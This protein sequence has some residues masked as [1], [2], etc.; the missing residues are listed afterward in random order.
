MNLNIKKQYKT[1]VLIVSAFVFTLFTSQK[2]NDKS[3]SPS[4]PNTVVEVDSAVE[5]VFKFDYNDTYANQWKTVDSL[6]SLGLY[7]SSLNVVVQIFDKAKK[8]ENH[9][10]VIKALM[11]KQKYNSYITDEDFVAAIAELDSIALVAKFPL[12][13]IA[14]AITADVY[15]GYFQ[16][17]QW[18]VGQRTFSDEIVKSDIR[19]WDLRTLAH[20]IVYH[21]IQSTTEATKLQALPL[22]AYKDILRY[23]GYALDHQKRED[24]DKF[25]PTLYDF[26]AFEAIKF[27]QTASYNVSQ[28][29]DKYVLDN[30]AILGNNADFINM[31]HQS[32]DSLSNHYYAVELFKTLTL[33]HIKDADPSVLV[34]ITIKRIEFAKNYAVLEN[35]EE[36]YVSLINEMEKLYASHESSTQFSYLKAQNLHSK[37][38]PLNKDNS[39]IQ[40]GNKLAYEICAN[41]QKLYPN[42]YG[43]KQ[44]K[45]LMNKLE[46][47]S[48][49]VTLDKYLV[50]ATTQKIKLS[51]ANIDKVYFTL[52]LVP[53]DYK[54]PEYEHQPKVDHF[55][56][57]GKKIKSWEQSVKNLGDYNKHSIE[58]PIDPMDFGHY[59]LLASSSPEFTTN[60]QAVHFAQFRV[61]NFTYQESR[62]NNS[63]LELSVFDRTSG[64]PQSKVKVNLFK[65]EWNS[66]QRRYDY[67]KVATYTTDIAGK[68][69]HQI[70][71][72]YYNLFVELENEKD[73]YFSDNGTY[74][75]K[76]N[77]KPKNTPVTHFFL[78]RKIYRPG[79]TIY[80]KG[81]V[82]QKTDKEVI[83][84]PN[85]DVTI[86]LKDVNY[87]KVAELRLK[88]NDYGSYSGQ[89][90]A[91]SGVLTGNMTLVDNYG[92]TFFSVE[93]YKRP[94][95]EVKFKPIEG[96]FKLDQEVTVIGSAQA[97]AGNPIDGAEVKY[98][99]TRS[100]RFPYWCWYRYG[101]MPNSSTTQVATGTVTSDEKGDFKIVFKAKGDASINLK[102]SP[103]YSYSITADVTDINGETRSGSSYVNVGKNAMEVSIVA[104]TENDINAFN[105]FR[106]QTRNLNYQPVN[107][108]GELTI[109]SLIVPS[110]VLKKR[111]WSAPDLNHL[112]KEEFTKLFPNDVY[113][114]EHLI[115]NYPIDKVVFKTN[116]DTEKTDTIFTKNSNL[117]PGVYK[118]E[119]KSIDVFGEEVLDVKFI[120]I[121]DNSSTKPVS[122]DIFSVR[123]VKS[124]L[125]PGENAEFILASATDV[126]VK[127][128][129]AHQG[130]IFK[131]GVINLKNE[132]QKFT[133]PILESHRGSLSFYFT[134]FRMDEC[135]SI[136]K[137]VYVPFSNKELKIEF[138]TFRNKLLPGQEETWK[139]KLSGPKSE[140]VAAEMVAAMYDAS[141][142]AFAPNYFDMYLN[143]AKNNYYYYP[144]NN[145]P[146]YGK[147]PSGLLS[148]GWNSYI[149]MPYRSYPEFNWFGYNTYRYNRNN[150]RMSDNIDYLDGDLDTYSLSYDEIADMPAR[151]AKTISTT[152]SG[153][154]KIAERLPSPAAEESEKKEEFLN[155]SG[156]DA[157]SVPSG[158]VASGEDKRGE[159]Q[160][161]D[162]SGVQARSN[163]N[164][165]AFFFPH[166][167]TNAKGEI[168]FS[169]TIPESLTKWKFLSFAHTKDLKKGTLSESIVTQKDLMVVPNAPRF[170]R[171]KDQIV[172][173]SKISNLTDAVLEGNVQLFLIDPLTNKAIDVELMNNQ[174][175]KRFTV[176]AKQSTSVSWNLTIPLGL[177]AL[178]YKIVAQSGNFTDGEE[179]TLPVLT[180]R[181]LVTESL[182]VY[183]N[184]KGTKVFQLSKL[185]NNTSTTLTHHNLTLEYTS[186]PAWYAIQALPYMME[187]PYECA[188]Q[189]FTRYYAN[190]LATN[191]ANS[192][193]KIKAVFDAWVKEGKEAFM[194]NLE[195]N[196]ELK[197]LFLEETPWVFNAHSEAESK[198]RIGLLFDLH[199]MQK[200]LDKALTKLEKEQSANGG[201]AWFKGFKENRYITQHII[202]GMGHLNKLGVINSTKSFREWKMIKKG[203]E[204]LDYEIIQDYKWLVKHS[205]NYKTERHISSIQIQYLYARSFFDFPVSKNLEEAYNYYLGQAKKYWL[206]NS[207][208]TRAMIALTLHRLKDVDGVQTKVMNHLKELAIINEEMGAYYKENEGG[209]YWD[210][211][212]IETHALII[213]AFDEVANDAVMVEDLKIWLL[214]Q[215]QTTHWKTTKSTANACYALLLRGTNLL[216]NEE[217]VD[218]KLGDM[219]IVPEKVEAG[220]GYFKKSWTAKEIKPEMGRVTITKQQDG[221][222]WGALYWQYFED[223][224]KITPHNTPLKITKKLFKVQIGT[225]GEYMTPIENNGT[226]KVGDKV[227]VRVEIYTDRNLEY[228]HLKDMRASGFEPINVL[229]QYKYRHGL[230]YYEATKDASTNFFID[231]LA[232]GTYVFEYDL[233]VFHQGDF[234]NGITTIQC[235]Y[236]PEFTSHSEGV[237]VVVK[238]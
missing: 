140:K 117:K 15:W 110:K 183:N 148:Y 106:V 58:L 199:K 207:L 64:L 227:R 173:T 237:R 25:T 202:S 113:E 165:T 166:L 63:T 189:T 220:T 149:S 211:A 151:S 10:Q 1:S 164:E 124:T 90:T 169:F 118:F 184:K 121:Y 125:E 49:D 20:R 167:E 178:T 14:H 32:K 155:Q 209:Y 221:A 60:N 114:N 193:P 57:N 105:Y 157:N 156:K 67:K 65:K 188:E 89:F 232:K 95:F 62:I 190:A 74:L 180:N 219:K 228:V 225:N 200:E 59:V 123:Q 147:A 24:F 171:E 45:S 102:Y 181:M 161:Q 54:N 87:Q 213:E 76:D 215:K 4:E 91:P 131:E 71:G 42:S 109:S 26:L 141:L 5:P 218:I 217:V 143:Y 17:N 101:F 29:E 172:L 168:I 208:Q 191:V 21:R 182:P 86:Q 72:S 170:F 27:F 111:T 145:F 152:V 2:C 146:C 83:V 177:Q 128:V 236:A 205:S 135:V 50:P 55:F 136:N 119:A 122:N 94:K 97:F 226:L 36:L 126:Y 35:K 70:S 46:A 176:A 103:I 187:Y 37:N 222:S 85:H 16:A 56:K 3:T 11:H 174:A 154:S 197:A 116:F 38:N 7:K 214:K 115:E 30:P 6:Q 206:E 130:E 34:D 195:K 68:V 100:A 96:V 196:Q 88:T 112:T 203:V 98:N 212:P 104:N 51:Y 192:S 107:A 185:I 9:P 153:N 162:L 66:L 159:G 19:T 73:Y 144:T 223:L 48:M 80:F 194:S 127:Y 41:A 133:L 61:T 28:N 160:Q 75:Y 92:S 99:I 77:Y 81:I 198:K 238:E 134:T 52:L 235:M 216:A 175:Q 78:D 108:K 230:G 132:Q 84:L 53:K 13:Q 31:Q 204:F 158:G 224:D 120:T 210:S 79:Q 8:E 163:F 23:E 69:K 12:K 150:Y 231:Y 229:S 39:E 186:N 179:M 201:W 43:A 18:E 137:S 33:F 142:D 234:S 44:C 82:T 129:I 233:R 47:K 93:E 40:K 138:E 139:I 22:S